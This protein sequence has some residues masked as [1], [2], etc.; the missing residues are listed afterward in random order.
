MNDK[1]KKLVK[2]M[3]LITIVLSSGANDAVQESVLIWY[4]TDDSL[5]ISITHVKELQ[6]IFPNL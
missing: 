6:K 5:W 1:F 3:L 4:G 2:D